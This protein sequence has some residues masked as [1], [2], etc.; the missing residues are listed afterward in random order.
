MYS[1]SYI[2]QNVMN[3]ITFKV[4]LADF[5]LRKKVSK[6]GIIPGPNFPAFGLNTER[7]FV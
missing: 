2:I 4:L 6:Y 7:Y 1:I 3:N 5:T